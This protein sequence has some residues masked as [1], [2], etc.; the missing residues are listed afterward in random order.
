MHPPMHFEPG[1]K[2]ALSLHRQKE[3]AQAQK[4]CRR[5]VKADPT[6]ADVKY[7]LGMMLVETGDYEW[8]VEYMRQAIYIAPAEPECHY[9]LGTALLKWGRA[10]EACD[11]YRRAI[12]LRPT[13]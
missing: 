13:Y 8:G 12:Q 5:L 7:L 1:L 2:Q 10:E 9:N 11:A 3:Y 6:R 4:I